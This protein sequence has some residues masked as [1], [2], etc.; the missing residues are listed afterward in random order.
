[1]RRLMIRSRWLL[2]AAILLGIG[3]CVTNQQL[4][5]FARSEFSR[6][7]ADTFGRAFQVFV[8]GTG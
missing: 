4:V 6:A 8:Q 3:G 1:M 2:S 7:I 5:D